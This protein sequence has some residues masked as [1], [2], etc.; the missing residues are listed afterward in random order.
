MRAQIP[1]QAR[2]YL[3][4]MRT[5][6]AARVPQLGVAEQPLPF[7]WVHGGGFFS[8]TSAQG[9]IVSNLGNIRGQPLPHA[10]ADVYNQV[11]AEVRPAFIIAFSNR[12]RSD[13]SPIKPSA[14][15][16]SG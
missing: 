12:A 13:P 14:N 16:A 15:L 11:A 4:R 3:S 2:K 10:S 8:S 9:A 1:R 7:P 5:P 6:E